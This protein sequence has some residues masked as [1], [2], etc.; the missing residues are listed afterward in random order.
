[1]PKEW[2]AG[3]LRALDLGAAGQEAK[4]RE[5]ERLWTKI[6][7]RI[8]RVIRARVECLQDA[9]D[10]FQVVQ[11]STWIYFDA[12][13]KHPVPFLYV[14]RVARTEVLK[15]SERTCKH[16]PVPLDS[17]SI[18]NIPDDPSFQPDLLA[19]QGQ[20]A[21][22]I[23]DALSALSLESRQIVT[24]HYYDGLTY[25]EIG[26]AMNL[27]IGQVASKMRIA[28]RALRLILKERRVNDEV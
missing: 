3:R 7:G 16:K 1:V 12:I 4:Y 2:Y 9:E 24:L 13:R 11:V 25:R 21:V 23:A 5:F 15:Y 14:R 10:L 8:F 18:L 22:R 19:L 6:G 17:R 20:E 28:I 27:S 26:A